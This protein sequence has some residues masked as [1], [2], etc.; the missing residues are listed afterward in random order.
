MNSVAV[1]GNGGIEDEDVKSFITQELVKSGIE[2]F[3]STSDDDLQKAE[4]VILLY[5]AYNGITFDFYR[6]TSMLF[7][8][9][10][11]IY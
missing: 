3:D 11:T 9:I 5:D 1:I 7:I 10:N 8:N 6:T 2:V 4:C